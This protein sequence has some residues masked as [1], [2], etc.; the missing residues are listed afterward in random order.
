MSEAYG[1]K[2]TLALQAVRQLH[3]DTSKLLVDY[4]KRRYAEGCYSVFENVATRDL[5][6]NVNAEYWM[7]QAVYRY[8]AND[9]KP[10]L[11]EGVTVCFFQGKIDEPILLAAQIQYQPAPNKLLKEQCMAWDVW[12]LFFEPRGER[13]PL[14]SVYSCRSFAR[15][16]LQWGKVLAAP[17]FS[18]KRVEQVEEMMDEVRRTA[19]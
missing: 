5:T 19:I 13:K 10:G 1:K 6:Y 7:A 2:I 17:L 12:D 16:N 4:D 14:R 11:V 18:I 9:A 15:D 3:G 8:Y